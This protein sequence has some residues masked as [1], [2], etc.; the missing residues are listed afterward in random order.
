[1]RACQVKCRQA[2]VKRRG[3]PGQCRVTRPAALSQPAIMIIVI[4]MAG[5]TGGR[6]ALEYLIDVAFGA[7]HISM[8][9]G[10]FEGRQVV[11]KAGS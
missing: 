8:G 2:V 3:F 11:I 4:F 1:M 10:Q 9:A 5:K 6:R 7:S